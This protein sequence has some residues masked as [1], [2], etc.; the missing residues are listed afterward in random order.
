MLRWV[1]EEEERLRQKQENLK[2]VI[3]DM[4][5]IRVQY[6]KIKFTPLFEK[7]EKNENLFKLDKPVLIRIF[8]TKFKF[9]AVT[10]IDSSGV[11]AICE[12]RKALLNRSIQVRHAGLTR[13]LI[14]TYVPIKD[15]GFMFFFSLR[16][17]GVG[18]SCWKRDGKA[19]SLENP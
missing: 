12:L 4:T 16:A 3:V 17:A 9:S 5:G 19:S 14:S 2:C 13:I 15:M 6:S 8:S 11:D 10:A 7:R 18:E 1:R